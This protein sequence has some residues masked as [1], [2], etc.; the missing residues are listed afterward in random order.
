MSAVVY[1]PP[2]PRLLPPDAGAG[3]RQYSQGDP[4]LDITWTG[5]HTEEEEAA[6][7]I[8]DTLG[9]QAGRGLCVALLVPQGYVQPPFGH[10]TAQV[11]AEIQVHIPLRV[12]CPGGNCFA[13]RRICCTCSGRVVGSLYLCGR[14]RSLA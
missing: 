12:C 9:R 4:N 13:N 3:T 11:E 1:L 14:V 8:L 6:S 2:H 10:A 5:V 7:T